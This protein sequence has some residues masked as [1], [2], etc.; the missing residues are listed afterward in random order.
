MVWLN[1]G[2]RS[3]T[4][5]LILRLSLSQVSICVAGMG[6]K[7][8]PLSLTQGQIYT[9]PLKDEVPVQL[10][11]SKNSP[12][13]LLQTSFYH[14]FHSITPILAPLSPLGSYER[15]LQ[16][17][18]FGRMMVTTRQLIEGGGLLWSC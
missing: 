13:F 2:I 12:F 4:G 11:L 6:L 16:D 3:L 5:N 17:K 9:K 14:N 10:S 7:G 1:S 8:Q 15:A 18:W